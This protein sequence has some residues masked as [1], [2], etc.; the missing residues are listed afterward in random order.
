MLHVV[1]KLNALLEPRDRP[2]VLLLAALMVLTA[3][4]QTAGVASIMPFLSVLSDPGAI[5]S[6]E[7]LNTAYTVLEFDSDRS[8]LYFL[9]IISFA[10]FVSGTALQALTF[11]AIN[12]FSH[13]QQ[14]E[15]SRRL[16]ADY[17]RRPFSFFLTRNSGD[18]SKTILNE[19]SQVVSGAMMPAMRLLSHFLLAVAII[20]LLIIVHPF[21]AV[22]VAIV[23][24]TVY[25]I[26]YFA[27][28]A[29][30]QRVG[31][32]R[33]V[34]NRERFTAAAEAFAGAKEIR[35]LGREQ[36]YL[37]R[38][39]LPS[40]RFARH[41]ANAALLNQLPLFAIEAVAF[42]GVLLL[43]LVLM[44]G[45]GGLSQALPL[46]GLYGLAG[47]QLIPAFQK[48]FAAVAN[49]RFNMAA[50]EEVLLDLGDREGSQ[51]FTKVIPHGERLVPSE[52]IR[53][54]DVCFTYPGSG[55]PSLQ[56]LSLDI[57]ARTTVGIVGSSGAGKSTLVDLL[58]GLLRPDSGCI[59]I[60]DTKVDH[61]N[62]RRW[63]AAVGYVPQH[64][65]LAD[66]SVA[67]NIA[68]GLTE[69]EID[70][71]AV[72][73]A[74]KLANL[75]EFVTQELPESYDTIIGERGVR[76]S[77]G[78]RQRIGIARAL[79]RDPD[80]LFFDEATS[81]LDN[82]T[83]RAVMEAIHNLSGHKT[84]VL[85]A[86]R[87]TTVRPCDWIFVMQGGSLVEEGDWETLSR[88][89]GQF[90]RLSAGI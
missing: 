72:I 33:V 15:L 13:M 57:P 85:V 87:L 76:L 28:R 41:Q 21:L 5:Q 12:R 40:K 39:R 44:A 65:F 30:L 25:G 11:W 51:S 29:W 46:I 47:R 82:A 45:E 27:A 84:I 77:G 88:S 60:D 66:Q 2:K 83:E 26:I 14:Y 75:N 70:R 86:H 68:L 69:S 38:Y 8:F 36:A 10:V 24:G 52:T 3:F 49:I 58:L 71:D 17:L 64:I 67:A 9:G 54:E 35:L 34:A 48:I 18:L 1:K 63:Q 7:W 80:V 6:N 23:L 74:A 19:T 20:S 90:K 37:E 56:G 79:Y 59:R 55:E 4:M 16:M 73:K 43:V 62:V 78:Q 22:S 81:A 50:V 89:S 32:E 31:R 42:G 61:S 53:V